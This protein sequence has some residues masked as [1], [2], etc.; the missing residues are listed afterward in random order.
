MATQLQNI[1][2]LAP[3][4]NKQ[5]ASGMQR[6]RDINLQKTVGQVP[7]GISST[8]AAQQIGA[9]QA[10]QAGQSQVQL[11]QRGQQQ[12]Q[13]LGQLALQQ[14][15]QQKQKTL[16]QKQFGIEQN[17]RQLEERFFSLSEGLKDKLFDRQLK[18]QRDELGRTLFNERQLADWTLSKAQSRQEVQQF[19]NKLQRESARR[20]QV[21]QTAQAKLRQ[22]IEQGY[23]SEKQSL[24]QESRLRIAEA[25]AAAKRKMQE[26]AAEQ[27]G[28]S[29]MLGALGT[30]GGMAIGAVLAPTG[31]GIP[32]MA[33]SAGLGGQIGGGLGRIGAGVASK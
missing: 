23:T 9:Q 32:I 21:M 18:F 7:K 19:S 11:Q 20:M 30:L 14:Q 15:E 17:R 16:A 6:A 22:A 5:L 25:A 13:Q 12:Q 27:A 4:S 2:N 1:A 26:E 31:A 29:G 28:F 33:A 8:K 3:A 10:Q 24:D